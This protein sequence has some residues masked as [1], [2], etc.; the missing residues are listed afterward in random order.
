M[1]RKEYEIRRYG[2]V[3][4]RQRIM[5]ILEAMGDFPVKATVDRYYQ[6]QKEIIDLDTRF[7]SQRSEESKNK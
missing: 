5:H 6:N 4:E 2:L 7:N 3:S 1:N